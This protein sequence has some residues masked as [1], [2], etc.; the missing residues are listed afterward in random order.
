MR[1]GQ[2]GEAGLDDRWHRVSQIFILSVLPKFPLQSRA[3]PSMPTSSQVPPKPSPPQREGWRSLLIRLNGAGPKVLAN[4]QVKFWI[5]LDFKLC[6]D[7]QSFIL[8]PADTVMGYGTCAWW[9]CCL[10]SFLC[11]RAFLRHMWQFMNGGIPLY[12]LRCFCFVLE[13]SMVTPI[14]PRLFL[15]GREGKKKRRNE[16]NQ[17]G[18]RHQ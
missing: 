2:K 15:R 3:V 10:E 6:S 4:I 14:P 11:R 5:S 18:N 9:D 7:S 12:I 16:G 13:C 1:I 17:L 8:I